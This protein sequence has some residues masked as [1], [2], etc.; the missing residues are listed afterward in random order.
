[1]TDPEKQYT[2]NEVLEVSKL[3][4]QLWQKYDF[5]MHCSAAR[6]VHNFPTA[7]LL[8]QAILEFE[9]ANR[10]YQRNV[11]EEVRKRQ[12]DEVE[13]IIKIVQRVKDKSSKPEEIEAF[14]SARRRAFEQLR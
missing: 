12:R 2:L 13:G 9:I 3:Y 1:M 7:N 4:M 10:N 5:A 8:E 14:Y 6:Q 11:P